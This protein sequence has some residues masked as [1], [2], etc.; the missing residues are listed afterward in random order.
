MA[1][2][3]IFKKKSAPNLEILKFFKDLKQNG[4]NFD[5][6]K[7]ISSEFGNFKKW[8]FHFIPDFLSVEDFQ[9]ISKGGV[10]EKIFKKIFR[11]EIAN[12]T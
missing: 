11:W 3:S 5:F 1:K 12:K 8:K 7:K 4:Q 2:I 10:R 9:K 6:L